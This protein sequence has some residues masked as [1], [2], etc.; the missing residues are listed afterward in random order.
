MRNRYLL[1]IIIEVTIHKPPAPEQLKY[2]LLLLRT[3]GIGSKTFIKVLHSFL[4][5]QLFSQSHTSLKALGLREKSIEFIKNPDWILIESDILWLQQPEND[6]VTIFDT[7]YPDQL[8][9]IDSPPPILF[10]RGN[11]SLLAN[12]QI[13]IVGSRNPSSVG[14]QIAIDFAYSLAQQGYTVTSG[15]ASGY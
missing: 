13:A 6:L 15:L 7:Q 5:H 14:I 4:P 8:K 9:E 2:W 1:T 3:P 12:P 11:K 10:V